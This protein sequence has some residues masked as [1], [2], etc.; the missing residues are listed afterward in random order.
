VTAKNAEI[1]AKKGHRTE[2]YPV[3]KWRLTLWSAV[4]RTANNALPRVA[5][6]NAAVGKTAVGKSAAG[7]HH[8][9][10]CAAYQSHHP[11]RAGCH[12]ARQQAWHS[13]AAEAAEASDA[14]ENAQNAHCYYPRRCI[15]HK[16]QSALYELY[17]ATEG[18]QQSNT[19]KT[20]HR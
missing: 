8:H 16:Q 10:F 2:S 6:G 1:T 18:S 9:V 19:Q 5:V 12:P 13:N 20:K 11:P 7:Q 17:F 15:Q 3:D 4:R 14:V